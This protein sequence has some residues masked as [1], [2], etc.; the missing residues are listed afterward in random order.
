MPKSSTQLFYPLLKALINCFGINPLQYWKVSAILECHC[1]S[2]KTLNFAL[3]SPYTSISSKSL[4]PAI[5][6]RLVIVKIFDK[7]KKKK[8]NMQA[9]P[10]STFGS[11]RN[12][13][14][15]IMQSLIP[16]PSFRRRRLGGQ[17]KGKSGIIGLD[18]RNIFTIILD[19]PQ[20]V[21]SPAQR[22]GSF[23][24]GLSFA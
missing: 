13:R 23:L 22:C 21:M 4:P 19:N 1:K 7:K 10:S 14:Q 17:L 6:D 18:K 5:T 9:S 11:K 16:V 24:S 3:L 12:G 2:Q 15:T 20:L 8:K